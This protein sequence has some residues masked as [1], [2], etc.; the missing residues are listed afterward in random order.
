MIAPAIV[1]GRPLSHPDLDRAWSAFV[2]HDIAPV[3]HVADQPRVFD[4]AWYPADD[5]DFVPVVESVFLHTAAALACTDLIANGTLERHP[6]L[7]I[8]SW[9]CRRCGFRCT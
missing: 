4:D 5:G 7:R 6:G 8:A 2:D 9:N 1:D 3:F